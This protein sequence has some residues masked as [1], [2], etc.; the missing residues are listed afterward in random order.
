MRSGDHYLGSFPGLSSCPPWPGSTHHSH[1]FLLSRALES[2]AFLQ[3][4][5]L[6]WPSPVPGSALLPFPKPREEILGDLFHFLH[7]SRCQDCR[8]CSAGQEGPRAFQAPLPTA[9]EHFHTTKAPGVQRAKV[10][11]CLLHPD[12][13]CGEGQVTCSIKHLVKCFA[14]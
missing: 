11:R 1:L 8:S 2:L 3:Q 13:P 12:L 7:A 9:Q 6:G 10:A 14:G 5:Q 4:H